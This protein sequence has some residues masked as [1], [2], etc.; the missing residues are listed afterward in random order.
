MNAT[1]E[2]TNVPSDK[3]VEKVVPTTE[4]QTASGVTLDNGL[5]LAETNPI[6]YINFRSEPNGPGITI[7]DCL[8]AALAR[9]RQAA[10]KVP[11]YESNKTIYFLERALRAQATRTSKREVRKLIGTDQII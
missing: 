5:G 2:A 3:V 10:N 11:S 4:T 1:V 8:E 9:T 7:E 6:R